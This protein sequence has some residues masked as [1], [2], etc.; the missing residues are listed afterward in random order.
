VDAVGSCVG[1][2]GIRIQNIVNEL[3]GEKI[4]VVQWSKDPATYIANALSPSMVMRVDLEPESASAVAIVP[5]RQLSLAIGKEG[6]NARL[7]ARLTGWRVDIRSAVEAV[8]PAKAEAAAPPAKVAPAEAP[9]KEEPVID[10][11]AAAVEEAARLMA[12][13]TLVTEPAAVEAELPAE[14]EAVV[15]EAPAEEIVPV[16]VLLLE[17]EPAPEPAAVGAENAA[18]PSL[19]DLPK[20]IWSIRSEPAMQEGVIRFAEDI[21]ELRRGGPGRG[22]RDAGRGVGGAAGKDRKT[23]AGRRR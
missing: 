2:R 9:A 16:E 18:V 6:Q 3:H 15:A 17:E 8:P 12:E 22:R 1:L 20:D 5:G 21:E 11:A 7:A 19:H 10:E 13:T 14:T 4:D 23:K